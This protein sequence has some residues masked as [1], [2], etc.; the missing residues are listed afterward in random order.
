MDS[1]IVLKEKEK[2]KKISA[3]QELKEFDFE[4]EIFSKLNYFD[5]EMRL[6]DQKI[7]NFSLGEKMSLIEKEINSLEITISE[8]NSDI[9]NLNLKIEGQQ[10]QVFSL[11][12]SIEK[13]LENKFGEKILIKI[14]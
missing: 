12:E 11:K 1:T 3:L 4:N 10:N 2:E 8:K 6:V 13:E 7:K 5:S 9:K 14:S